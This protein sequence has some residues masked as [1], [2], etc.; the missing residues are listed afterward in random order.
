MAAT[1]LDRNGRVVIP[2]EI[3]ARYGLTPGTKVE[4]IDEG[5]TLRSHGVSNVPTRKRGTG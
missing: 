2:A 4:I 1:T 3:R 5:G